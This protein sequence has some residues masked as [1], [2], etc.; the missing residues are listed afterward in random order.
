MSSETRNCHTSDRLIDTNPLPRRV[1]LT[2][3]PDSSSL[4]GMRESPGGESPIELTRVRLRDSCFFPRRVDPSP[5][6][7][8]S[9]KQ[10]RCD[11]RPMRVCRSGI[12][13]SIRWNRNPHST[14]ASSSRC[15]L[16]K[17]ENNFA[18]FSRSTFTRAHVSTIAGTGTR[19][20]L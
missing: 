10:P 4:S 13:E 20:T 15:W 3:A 11:D 16:R 19:T 5:E 14:V 18:F 8:R 2:R 17:H 9:R 6:N 7:S 1:F 12:H